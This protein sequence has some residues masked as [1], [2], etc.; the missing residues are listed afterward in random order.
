MI[1]ID[2]IKKKIFSLTIFINVSSLERSKHFIS[3]K[4]Q[5]H[6]SILIRMRHI[7]I[8]VILCSILSTGCSHESKY[9]Y[10]SFFVDGI[11]AA[12]KNLN[13]DEI[14][15][16]ASKEAPE[17]TDLYPGQVIDK[18]FEANQL[19]K[20]VGIPYKETDSFVEGSGPEPG[21]EKTLVM[22]R[23]LRVRKENSEFQ[24][25]PVFSL[26]VGAFAV[27]NNADSFAERLKQKGY[28]VFTLIT[29][30]DD[31]TLL[32]R[33]LVGRFY[34]KA[35]AIERLKADLQRDSIEAFVYCH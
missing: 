9:Q 20:D 21:L 11:P 23:I 8:A 2:L 32:H 24:E 30:K 27:R 26:Q 25:K 31:G 4:R 7:I 5:N 10:L 3:K 12:E 16:T 1:T 35:E 15:E 28:D 18:N 19:S 29:T 14:N 6:V 22:R 33:V 34:E 13:K 17:K